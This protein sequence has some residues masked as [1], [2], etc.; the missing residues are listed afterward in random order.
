MTRNDFFYELEGALAGL[1]QSEVN[2]ILEYYDEIFD[3]ALEDGKTEEEICEGLDNPEDIAGRV[4]AEIAFVRAEQQ[5]SAKSISTVLV[6][7]LGILALP[8][9]LPIAI[10]VFAVVFA[11]VVTVFSIVVSLGAAMF[12]LFA[13][14]LVGIV[15]GIT[16]IIQGTPLFG[17]GTIGASFALVGISILGSFAVYYVFRAMFR[18][19]ARC[20]RGLYSWVVNRKNRRG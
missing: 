5:P 4:R 3:G 16:L 15:Y 14:G 10:A 1:P 18:L 9:G 2:R 11:M 6:V 20:C 13:G 7:L 19:I 12:G 8:I 17:L